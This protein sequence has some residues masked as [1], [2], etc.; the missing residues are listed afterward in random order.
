MKCVNCETEVQALTKY[1]VC[2]NC[3]S[4]DDSMLKD[5]AETKAWF[6]QGYGVDKVKDWYLDEDQCLDGIKMCERI[7]A[8]VELVKERYEDKSK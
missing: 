1:R 3:S 8:Y 2:S 4:W 7:K 5:I 6:E